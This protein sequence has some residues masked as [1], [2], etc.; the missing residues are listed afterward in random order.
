[1][2]Q[3]EASSLDWSMENAHIMRPGYAAIEYRL[4]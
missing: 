4:L 2:F 1:M 3:I